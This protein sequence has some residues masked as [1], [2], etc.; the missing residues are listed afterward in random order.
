MLYFLLNYVYYDRPTLHTVW[1]PMR[2]SHH[3]GLAGYPSA[4]TP[5]HPNLSHTTK[6]IPNLVLIDLSVVTICNAC[7]KLGVSIFPSEWFSM[8]SRL[9]P[10][11]YKA[12]VR[13]ISPVRDL[14]SLSKTN[15]RSATECNAM[16]SQQ[17]L[18]LSSSNMK[19]GNLSTACSTYWKA[20]GQWLW[21]HFWPSV[22]L[23]FSSLPII[24]LAEVVTL[25]SGWPTVSVEI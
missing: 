21:A 2:S 5:P 17:W 19:K 20:C 11:S 7:L 16:H 12:T 23:R 18:D 10:P 14:P 15:I 22:C 1:Q 6:I 8:H 9:P 4:T 3:Q 25:L 13:I 24:I